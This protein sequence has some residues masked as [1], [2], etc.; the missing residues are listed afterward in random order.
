MKRQN[1]RKGILLVS[2]MLFPATF[3]YLSPVLIIQGASEGVINGSFILFTLLFLSSFIFG[4]GFC[5]W[6]CPAGG[7]QECILQ[8][9]NKRAKGKW[10]DLIKY[11]IWIPWIAIIAAFTISSGGYRFIDPFYQT[12]LGLSISNVYALIIY[13]FVLMLIAISSFTAGRRALCH[14]FC[15]MAPFMI[16]GTK[17]RSLFKY[18]YLHLEAET[19]KCTGCKSCTKK[20]PMSLEVDTMVARGDMSN[21]ECILCGE[22]TNACPRGVI[23]YS[24][25][26]IA[27]FSHPRGL[28]PK[29]LEKA[30]EK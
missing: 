7:V 13:L 14:Y 12:E 11:F 18:P 23:K 20:C 15:W 27:S 4:R 3:Y 30:R 5:G 10:R 24:Y 9:A 19:V 26:H 16:I 6:V 17:L 8:A 1:I 29:A 2:F 21:T 25:R 28:L 22:C